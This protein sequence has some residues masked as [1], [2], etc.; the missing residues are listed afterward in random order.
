MHTIATKKPPSSAKGSLTRDSIQNSPE[1][2]GLPGRIHR[3]LK[4]AALR[5]QMAKT[6]E[7]MLNT[8]KRKSK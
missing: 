4:L 1:Q 2:P 3:L 7:H 8:Y 5:N 6:A